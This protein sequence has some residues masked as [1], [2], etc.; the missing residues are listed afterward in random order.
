MFGAN[1][2]HYC[3]PPSPDITDEEITAAFGAYGGAMAFG[4]TENRNM[5]NLVVNLVN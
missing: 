5:V 1:F 3:W 2:N 4:I